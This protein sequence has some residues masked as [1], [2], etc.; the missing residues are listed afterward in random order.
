MF[1]G[2]NSSQCITEGKYNDDDDTV[3]CGR[4]GRHRIRGEIRKILFIPS[5]FASG[6]PSIN[7]RRGKKRYEG[8]PFKVG[9]RGGVRV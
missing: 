5:F 2:G 4:F 7:I 9:K 8:V 1:L 6:F 3:S